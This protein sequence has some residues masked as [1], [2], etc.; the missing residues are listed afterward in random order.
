MLSRTLM[1]G[2][3]SSTVLEAGRP[4]GAA[5]F[6][7][8]LLHGRGGTPEAL[9]ELGLRFGLAGARWL[10]PAAD[11]GSWYPNR[12]MEPVA[13]NEPFLSRA[14]ERCDAVIG[15]A[16]EGGRLR[17]G[18]LAVVGFSQ[19]ACLAVEYA[20]RHPGRCGALVVFT[21]GLI[22]P[23]GTDWQP[24]ARTLAGLRVLLTGSNIDEWV[25]EARVRETAQVLTAKGA[26][27]QLHV[28]TGRPH[29]VS[30]AEIV[31]ARAFLESWL[32]SSA[33]DVDQP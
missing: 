28:Y 14:V 32:A 33:G 21:G 22:G 3:T 6:A 26:D 15:D 12:F 25:P 13:A 2:R 17:P 9:I 20:L 18:R 1:E 8:V 16:A 30:D 29:I 23:A 27:V 19:G 7:G 11:G 31:E 10:A 24:A 5:E 4:Q